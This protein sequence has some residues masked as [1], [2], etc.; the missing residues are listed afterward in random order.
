VCG[1]RAIAQPPF[2]T[3]AEEDGEREGLSFHSVTATGPAGVGEHFVKLRALEAHAEALVSFNALFGG[4]F[5][6]LQHW[7]FIDRSVSVLRATRPPCRRCGK[8]DNSHGI[9]DEKE[10]SLY[11]CWLGPAEGRYLGPDEAREENNGQYYVGRD[12]AYPS[13]AP[14]CRGPQPRDEAKHRR[15][16]GL[17]RGW[18]PRSITEI[19]VAHIGSFAPTQENGECQGG[20]DAGC[21]DGYSSQ[22]T[23]HRHTVQAILQL[24]LPS[25]RP[26][27]ASSVRR[28]PRISCERA[29]SSAAP[30][31]QLHALV[32]RHSQLGSGR[33]AVEA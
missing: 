33:A 28:T 29:V 8:N 31:R 5:D 25:S 12:E 10:D 20:T 30:A 32:R 13:G 6:V 23:R 19:H 21:P 17:A 1:W 26:E 11:L 18:V 22:D 27:E 15:G 3:S 14:Q 24:A 2:K 9:G 7:A 16:E 4:A